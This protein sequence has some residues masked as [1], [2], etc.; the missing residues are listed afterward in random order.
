MRNQGK[1]TYA[2]QGAGSTGIEL[3][4]WTLQTQTVGAQQGNSVLFG[5]L[6]HTF[7]RLNGSYLAALPALVAAKVKV[8]VLG[9]GPDI[10]LDP[11]GGEGCLA[12]LAAALAAVETAGSP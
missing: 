3:Q 7:R 5:D 9:L 2:G 4:A 8:I 12:L 11:Q 6:G 10:T 1:R